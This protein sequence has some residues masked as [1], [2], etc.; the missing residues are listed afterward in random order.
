MNRPSLYAA[1]GD[2]HALYIKA[3]KQYWE[4]AAAAM[5]EALTDSDPTLR[6]TQK[7]ETFFRIGSV[8]SMPIS[9]RVCEQQSI[10]AN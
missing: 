2:K 5:H 4:F 1:F 9:K 3:F 8:G 6:Q 10:P 7:Y